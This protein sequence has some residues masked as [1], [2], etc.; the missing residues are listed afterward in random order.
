[1]KKVFFFLIFFYFLCLFQT[2]FLANFRVFGRTPNLVLL[3]LIIFSVFEGPGFKKFRLPEHSGFLSAI[4]G[5]F[6]LDIFSSSRIGFNILIFLA[7][8]L[9]IR[10]IIKKYVRS[11]VF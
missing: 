3:S 8:F 1:M 2:S 7:I 10:L 4:F 9:F 5:G 11:P 6:F